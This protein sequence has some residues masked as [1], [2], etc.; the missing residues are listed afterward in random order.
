MESDDPFSRLPLHASFNRGIADGEIA[1]INTPTHILNSTGKFNQEMNGLYYHVEVGTTYVDVVLPLPLFHSGQADHSNAE[2]SISDHTLAIPKKDHSALGHRLCK[3]GFDTGA[4]WTKTVM[5]NNCK[6]IPPLNASTSTPMLKNLS[7]MVFNESNAQ[8]L[9]TSA[10]ELTKFNQD[11]TEVDVNYTAGI[12]FN[13]QNQNS[14]RTKQMHE[15]L[16]CGYW[17]YTAN[18]DAGGWKTD[19]C[20]RSPSEN[21]IV[22]CTC[23]HLTNFAVLIDLQAGGNLSNTD[24]FV[25]GVITKGGLVVSTV[26]LSFTILTFIVF[27]HLRKGRGQQVLFNLSVAM[28]CSS[29]LFLVGIE[30]TETRGGCIAVGVLLHY[31]ILVSFMWMLVEGILQYLRFVKVLGTYIPTFMVKSMLAAWGM[32]L[33]PIIA[34]LCVDKDLYKNDRAYCWL[35]GRALLYAFVLPLAVIIVAN[36]VIFFLIVRQFCVRNNITASSNRSEHYRSWL[37][38]KAAVSIFIVLGLTWIFGFLTV[39]DTRIAFHYIFAVLNAFQGFFIFMMFTL[40]EKRIRGA[41]KK[42]CCSKMVKMEAT[43]STRLQHQSNRSEIS[44]T[45]KQV[46]GQT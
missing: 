17:D 25:L 28:L 22:K 34:V 23:N 37:Q 27:R 46:V 14:S 20:N 8:T 32:P 38:L 36:T 35:S 43:S 31:F 13:Y 4:T 11:L 12:M 42:L 30:R 41:W 10:A 16:V 1:F 9:L 33:I 40:R 2:E 3:G 44:T 5:A 24:E 7:E 45:S 21:F 39:D 18:Q 19:G 26:G 29:V 6:E 15:N